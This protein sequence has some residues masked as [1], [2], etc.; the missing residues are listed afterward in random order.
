MSLNDELTAF[1]RAHYPKLPAA[2]REVMDRAGRDL[3]ASGQAE[4]ALH[5]GDTAPGFRLP[6]ATGDTVTLDG[7]LSTGPVV[8]TFYRGAWCPFCNFALHALQQ[9][10]ADITARGARLVAISPQVPDE[11]LTLTEKHALA[12]DVLSDLGS[13]TAKQ[14]GLSFD[15]PE[16]LAA[17]Y[18][19]LGFDLQRV[20]GGHPR[21]LPLP[22]TYVIDRDATIRWAFV[23]TDY[24]RRAEPSDI[25]AALDAL[26][27]AR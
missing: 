20:N 14:Y 1:F 23:D 12:F 11:S 13:D 27:P 4:R 15:L 25:L 10:H 8:L 26:S 22:A 16:D 6:T 21:T 7:L 17:V 24:T 9:Q 5:A 3:A 18:D 2:A 19:S